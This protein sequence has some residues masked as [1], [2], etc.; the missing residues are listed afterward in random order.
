MKKRECV[1]FIAGGEWQV[2]L[3]K[4][5][6]KKGFHITLVDPY[7]DSPCVALADEFIQL[8]V[9]SIDLIYE[10]IKDKDLDY[11]LSDQTDVAVNSVAVLSNKLELPGNSVFSTQLFSNKSKSRTFVQSF[12]REI[13]PGFKVITS[14]KELSSFVEEFKD[15]II[16]PTDAQSSRGINRIENKEHLEF[17]FNE[18]KNASPTHSVIVEEFLIGEEITVEG[19]CLDSKHKTLT[20]SSKKHIKTGIASDLIFPSNIKTELLKKIYDFNDAYV[21]KSGLSSG[22]THAEY[23]VD[24]DNN[25]FWLVEIACRGGG[26]LIPSDIVP[27]VTGIDLYEH[28][29]DAISGENKLNIGDISSKSAI[30]HFFNFKNG[31]IKQIH[32]LEEIEK[33]PEVLTCRLSFS[34]GDEIFDVNDDRGR[35]GFVIILSENEQ[36]IKNTLEEVYNKI[37]ITYEV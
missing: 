33:I 25:K 5:L 7:E 3:V 16:K 9:K 29:F 31:L 27:W 4:F 23:I 20:T 36:G 21:D 8:D 10:K 18:A 17:Y 15:V 30:L 22:I 37:A 6:K 11:V 32:G 13:S 1:L 12:A 19:I 35:H 24:Q 2:P 34:A 14:V 28:L 26:T